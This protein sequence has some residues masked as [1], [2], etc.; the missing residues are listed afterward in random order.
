[1]MIEVAMGYLVYLACGLVL[2]FVSLYNWSRG[3]REEQQRREMIRQFGMHRS[4]E[5][6]QIQYAYAVNQLN[7]KK[8]MEIPAPIRIQ[9]AEC[10]ICF[11]EFQLTD[12]IAE[13]KCDKRHFFHSF[14][15]E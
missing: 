3:Q 7:R 8:F 11:I 5:A 6:S 14:C 10:I 4:I 12:E 1:M 13:L 15:I 9:N 2:G